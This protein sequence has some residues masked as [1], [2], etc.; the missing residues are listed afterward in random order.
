M[1]WFILYT[2]FIFHAIDVLHV[3]KLL[4]M[5]I[6]LHRHCYLGWT[7][8]LQVVTLEDKWELHSKELLTYQ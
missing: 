4:I 7:N 3:I 2:F 6:M 1:M 5:M 8:Q